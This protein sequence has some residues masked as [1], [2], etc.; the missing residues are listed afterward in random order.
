M[1]CFVA[2]RW[3]WSGL[4]AGDDGYEYEVGFEGMHFEPVKVEWLMKGGTDMEKRER[5]L[6]GGACYIRKPREIPSIK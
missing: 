6:R 5:V 3:C 4:G 1:S 2:G